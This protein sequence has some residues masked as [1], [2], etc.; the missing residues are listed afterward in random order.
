[1]IKLL[2]PSPLEQWRP[3]SDLD[4]PEACMA[5]WQTR[6]PAFSAQ[7]R[8]NRTPWSAHAPNCSA[9]LVTV[10]QCHLPPSGLAS[11]TASTPAMYRSSQTTSQ[12]ASTSSPA[13]HHPLL[14]ADACHSGTIVSGELPCPQP[15]KMDSTPYRPPPRVVPPP[16]H[17]RR[18]PD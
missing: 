17:R 6:P 16:P 4:R 3:T 1:L 11:T 13:A 12:A 18:W 5:K 2:G 14:P 10:R 15:P 9:S 7:A 8:H